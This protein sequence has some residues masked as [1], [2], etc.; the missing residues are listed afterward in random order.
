MNGV[1]LAMSLLALL[2][3]AAALAGGVVVEL[4]LHA[5]AYHHTPNAI[6]TGKSLLYLSSFSFAAAPT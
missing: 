3:L 2:G 6:N 4:R 1:C 5:A